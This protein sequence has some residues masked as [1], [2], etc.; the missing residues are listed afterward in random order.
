MM[1]KSNYQNVFWEKSRYLAMCCA[2]WRRKPW[3]LLPPLPGR[4]EL[5]HALDLSKPTFSLAIRRS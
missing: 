2:V 4:S 5:G 1:E 3:A